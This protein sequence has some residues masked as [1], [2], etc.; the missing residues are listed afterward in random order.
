MIVYTLQLESIAY[1]HLSGHER[2][3]NTTGGDQSN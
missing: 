2:A 3:L 1:T